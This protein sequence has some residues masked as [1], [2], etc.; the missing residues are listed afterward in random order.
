MKSSTRILIIDNYDSFV[1]N[2]YQYVGELTTN[3]FVKR[4]KVCIKDIKKLDPDAIIISPGPG[5]PKNAGNTV[6]IIE[7][8]YEDIPILGVCL[9]HQAIAYAFG[10]EIIRAKKVMHGKTSKIIHDGRRIYKGLKNPFTATRYHS[11]VV[12]EETLPEELIVVSRSLEDNE[13]MGIRHKNYLVEGVQFHPESILTSNGKIII[14]N[15]LKLV[16]D[17]TKN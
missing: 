4:N 17:S 11:L 15:F 6:K 10:A 7:E 12:A 14:R 8:F 16:E 1:F 3:V 13:I 5:E 9:G 2:L